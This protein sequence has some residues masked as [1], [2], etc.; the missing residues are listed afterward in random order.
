[1]NRKRS[2]TTATRNGNA[3]SHRLRVAVVGLGYISQRAVLPAFAHAR[4]AVELSAIVSGTPAKLETLRRKYR[5]PHAWNYEEF[6]A[7]MHGDEFDAVYIALPNHLH[8]RCAVRAA[9]AGKHVLC[10]KP[11]ALTERDCDAMIA[12]AR[13]HDVR[14]MI[15]YRLHLDPVNLHAIELVRSGRLGELQSF[16]SSFGTPVREGDIRTQDETG[17]GTLWDIGIYCI[18]AARYLFRS[19]PEEVFAM[20][21]SGP[22]PRFDDIEERSAALLRFPGG[23]LATIWSSFTS[24]DVAAYTVVGSKGRLHI[25]NVYE[26]H[27]PREI[28]LTI[29]DK[30]RRRREPVHDQ[31]AAELIYFADCVRRRAE[32][33]P[34]GLEGRAD[35]AIIRALYRSARSGRPERM[36][37]KGPRRRPVPALAIRRPAVRRPPRLVKTPA[38]RPRQASR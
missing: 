22:R 7:A 13:D 5:V 35:V 26:Y 9:R 24:T 38:P 12:A 28:T 16:E 23:R 32:P 17:G 2:K 29:G 33:I 30:T 37:P 4:G 14:L 3:R 31:F 27:E 1:M 18:N 6:D 25:D 34:S 19:E 36:S 8:R 21:A 11:M 10:E 15:A 20:T